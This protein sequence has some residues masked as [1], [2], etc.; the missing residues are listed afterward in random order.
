M[1]AGMPQPRVRPFESRNRAAVRSIAFDTGFMGEPVDWLWPDRDSF[2]DLITNYYVEREPESIFVAEQDGVVVGYLMGCIDSARSHGVVEGELRRL[3]RRGFLFRRGAAA[4]LWRAAFDIL[5]DRGAP[6]E[7]L[8]D[9]R[10]PAHLHINL[11]PAGRGCGLGRQLVHQWF[12]RLY[13]AN[14]AGVHLGTFAEN[15]NAIRFFESCGFTR[16]GAPERAPGFRTRDG[17]RM[18]VQ[19]MV[20]DL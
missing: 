8:N 11:L 14:V 5:H 4:F 20:R 7:A 19:W 16:H 13:R 9:P 12:D 17:E 10:W 6:P 2:A 3:V 15:H 1:A 18:H